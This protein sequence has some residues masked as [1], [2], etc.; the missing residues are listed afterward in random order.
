MICSSSCARM[1][2][3]KSCSG[4]SLITL[5]RNGGTSTR[6]GSPPQIKY[7]EKKSGNCR[8]LY[9]TRSS[10]LFRVF[11]RGN[12]QKKKKNVIIR[13]GNAYQEIWAQEF[14]HRR[15]YR[16]QQDQRRHDEQVH[17]PIHR[18]V[19][20]VHSFPAQELAIMRSAVGGK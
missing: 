19:E 3:S 20:G 18:T 12:E 16:L 8:S 5:T 9:A 11:L 6:V 2:S 17:G 10:V 7:R 4:A 13:Q 14:H 1:E 15:Y